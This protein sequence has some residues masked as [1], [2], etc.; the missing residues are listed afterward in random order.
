[1]LT[2]ENVCVEFGGLRALNNLSFSMDSNQLV[3]LVG[4]NGAGKTTLFNVISGLVKPS[5]G[6]IS[7]QDKEIGR[8]PIYRRAR[9]GIGRTFQIPQPLHELT[10]RENLVVAQ[11]F[12]HGKVD[13]ARIHEILAFMD[14]SAHAERDAA[15]ELSL[16]ELKQLEVAKALATEP[17][18]LLLDEVLAGLESQGKRYFS[19]KLS[20]LQRHFRLG[21][22]MIEHDIATVSSLCERVVVLDFGQLIADGSPASVFQDAKVIQSYTGVA[23]A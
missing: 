1:M 23:H 20:E 3:G 8:Q 17:Q 6:R 14:L 16:Q 22:L 5:R 15:S 19:A 18:L 21:I 13:H 11:R 9:S 10:V 7:F 2:L 12:G 4:P